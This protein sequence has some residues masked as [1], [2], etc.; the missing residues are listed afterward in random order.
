M[1]KSTAEIDAMWEAGQI[2]H[3]IPDDHSSPT[4]DDALIVTTEDAL[5][6]AHR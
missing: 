6:A 4:G 3:G 1:L 2:V 5:A